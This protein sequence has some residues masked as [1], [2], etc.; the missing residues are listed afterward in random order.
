[1]RFGRRPGA[2]DGMVAPVDFHLLIDPLGRAAE[3]QFAEGDQIAFREEVL[4]GMLNLLRNVDLAV[5]QPLEQ[6]VRRKVDQL[7][8]VRPLDHGIRHRLPYTDASNLRHDIIQAFQVLDID[9]REDRNACLQ[10][11]LHVLPA[12]RM[13]KTGRIR[14]CQFVE[15]NDGGTARKGGIE[16]KFVE[17]GASVLHRAARAIPRD[18]EARLQFPLFHASR[19]R[20]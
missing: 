9:G 19:R 17:H 14:V 15:K 12:L 4:N 20:R 11:L 13:S 8:I 10:Q 3:S 2:D 16:V 18:Q 6:I 5:F 7:D 1:M